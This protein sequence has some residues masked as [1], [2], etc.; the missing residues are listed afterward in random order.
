LARAAISAS[1]PRAMSPGDFRLDAA[2]NVAKH[3]DVIARP[4]P[5]LQVGNRDGADNFGRWSEYRHRQ[6]GKKLQFA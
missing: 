4:V 5:R 6:V 2:R 3:R 1:T